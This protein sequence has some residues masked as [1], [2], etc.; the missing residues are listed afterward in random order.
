MTLKLIIG[1]KNY[2]SW[3]LRTWLLLREA[4]IEFTEHRIAL[5]IESTAAEIAKVSPAGTVPVLQLDD[6][7]VWD[8]LAIAETVAERY[9]Q[10][11]LWP[12]DAAVRAHARSICAEM[13]AGF[14]VLRNSM[15]MNCRAM[16]RKVPLPDNLT[17]EIDRI[18]AIWSDC[19]H[20]YGEDNGWLFGAFSVADAMF[21]PVVLRFR[22]YGINL[23][24]SALHYP[25]RLLRSEAMQEWL[26]AAESE[27]EVIESDEKGR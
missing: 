18:F 17:R 3:S 14:A 21:A 7:T 11:A 4:G 8:T 6:L 13:H 22:T 23:P 26:A 5:D 15:P 16:G 10:A 19:Y 20:R 25:H 12:A 9:P 2:S 1:N 27:T 24:E